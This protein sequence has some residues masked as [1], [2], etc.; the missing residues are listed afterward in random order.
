MMTC[1]VC[2][3]MTTWRIVELANEVV[4]F[5]S[6]HE[7]HQQATAYTSERMR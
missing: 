7:N 5:C 6:A 3:R 1:H 4:A 2:G